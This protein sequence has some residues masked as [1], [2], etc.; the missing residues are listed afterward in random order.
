MPTV[1]RLGGGVLGLVD[2]V[3]GV[4]WTIALAALTRLRPG[5]RPG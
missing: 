2:G 1:R 5:S 4:Q 3:D